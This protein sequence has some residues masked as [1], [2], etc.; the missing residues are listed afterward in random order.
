M[1]DC[2]SM[3]LGFLLSGLAVV[4]FCPSAPM[5]LDRQAAQCLLPVLI[6]ALPIFDTALVIVIR[7]RE[8]R[9]ISQ[10]G[11]DH[12]SHRLVYTGLSDKQAVLLLYG[13]SA[14]GGGAA[15][16]VGRLHSS[17][18]AFVAV[19]IEAALLA[20]FGT[21]LNRF[22]EPVITAVRPIG[23]GGDDE[24]ASRSRAETRVPAD[25]M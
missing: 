10:G 14:V 15:L 16:L 17:P 11:R 2:G 21:Y 22:R 8:G 18:A 5:P 19:A 20:Y 9:A 3:V 24:S 4:V 12:S 6:M 25:R 13:L 1:G 23:A 7:K